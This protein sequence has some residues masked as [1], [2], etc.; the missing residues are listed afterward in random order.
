MKNYNVVFTQTFKD[1]VNK[2]LNNYVFYSPAYAT[3]IRRSL[4]NTLEF[5]KIFPYATST[6][7]FRGNPQ[8]YRKFVIQKRFLI[9]FKLSHNTIYLSYFI[10]GRKSPKNYL[11]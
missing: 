5:L 8:V 7:K 11:R 6:I 1:M 9:V 3:K 10:D 4:Y 2:E